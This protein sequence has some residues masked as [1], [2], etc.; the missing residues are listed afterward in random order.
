MGG[1]VKLGRPFLG[2]YM[3]MGQGRTSDGWMVQKGQK[4]RD[5]LYGCSL[6]EIENKMAILL[7][8][9]NRN[10]QFINVIYRYCFKNLKHDWF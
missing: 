4:K 3:K 10:I 1:I 8:L 7:S 2:R 5:V 9:F 6:I